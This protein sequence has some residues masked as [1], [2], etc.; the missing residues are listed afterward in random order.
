MFW[1][2]VKS[3]NDSA[4]ADDGI[5]TFEA[6]GEDTL[7]TIWGRQ[8]FRLP[9]LWAA[10]DR[11]LTPAMK[12]ALVSEAYGRFFNRTFA[13]LEAVAEGRDVRIG[14]PWSDAPE[15]EPLPVERLAGLV[16]K[17]QTRGT[18][19]IFGAAL[20]SVLVRA[21][22]RP[23]KPL[24]IDADGFRH[25][26]A[27]AAQRPRAARSPSGNAADLRHC[28]PVDARV[29][30]GSGGMKALVTGANGLIGANLVRELLREGLAVTGLVRAHGRSV[31]HR[32]P[33]RSS[34]WSGDVL[35]PA[36][37]ARPSPG[38]DVVF[39]TAVAFSYWGHE[40]ARDGPHGHR[41]QPQRPGRRRRRPGV[42]AGGDDLL[43]GDPGRILQARGPRRGASA[44]DDPDESAY[45]LAK[46]AQEREALDAARRLGVEIVFACPTMSVGPFGAGLGPSNGIVTSYLADPLR[47]DLGGRL[48][49]RR[50]CRTWPAG[51]LLLAR[52]GAAGERYVLGGENLD[53]ARH[54]RHGRRPGWRRRARSDRQRGRLLRLGRR[55]GAPRPPDRQGPASHPRAGPDGRALLLVQP[56]PRRR[57]RLPAPA[58]PRGAGRGAG[59]AGRLAPRL[60]RDAHGHAASREVH[61]ARLRHRAR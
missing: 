2:T 10:I 6:L 39:H 3:E 23:A 22:A 30:A 12:R 8:H 60:A 55:R 4:I 45:V 35:D 17:L 54:P 37:L 53:W 11:E 34:S 5:V 61:A 46:I 28:R 9:P 51:H 59:L 7:V 52:R 41:G 15:G 19:A 50:R 31:F 14:R 13:N 47:P 24:R 16:R 26:D 20:K 27:A 36:S 58:S 43:L 57:A 33:V 49:H 42:R 1:K 56:R 40:P 25:F 44:Q 18:A 21:S 32:R 38:Q 29:D 48:Q